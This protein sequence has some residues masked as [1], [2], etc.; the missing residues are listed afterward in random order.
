VRGSGLSAKTETH[1]LAA[2]GTTQARMMLG[3]VTWFWSGGLPKWR[4]G[5]LLVSRSHSMSR[6][7][8]SSVSALA[9]TLASLSVTPA[10]TRMVT[11]KIGTYARNVVSRTC[12][13]THGSE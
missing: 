7:P 2:T 4:E 13:H 8:L 12:I 10:H 1:L 5:A 6:A 3:C 11:N 9:L